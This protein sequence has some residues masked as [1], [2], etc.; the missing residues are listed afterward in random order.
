[1]NEAHTPTMR[2]LQRLS[3]APQWPCLSLPG[4]QLARCTARHPGIAACVVKSPTSTCTRTSSA[5]L[6]ELNPASAKACGCP[7]C[8]QEEVSPL[9]PSPKNNLRACQPLC[10]LVRQARGR[11]LAALC[12]VARPPVWCQ[13]IHPPPLTTNRTQ[14]VLFGMQNRTLGHFATSVGSLPSA[15]TLAGLCCTHACTHYRGCVGDAATATNHDNRKPHVHSL[16][17]TRHA[18]ASANQ[19]LISLSASMVR[20][21]WYGGCGRRQLQHP[22]SRR[23]SSRDGRVAAEAEARAEAAAQRRPVALPRSELVQGQAPLA[24]GAFAVLL[25]R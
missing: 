5:A 10:S 2:R 9:P 7:T 18:I 13:S 16:M 19:D 11:Y 14:F 22:A 4:P 17:G 25:L 24:G 1:M 12:Q 8:R 3:A 21:G 6:R 15:A 20:S 23:R